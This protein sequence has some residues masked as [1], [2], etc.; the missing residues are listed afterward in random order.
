MGLKLDL[1]RVVLALFILL[2][3]SLWTVEAEVFKTI[4]VSMPTNYGTFFG[5]IHYAEKDL[6]LALKA[7]RIIKEDL[8][9]VV[10]YFEY[11]PHDVVHF[12]LDPYLRLTNGN[13]VVFPT[14]I[15]NLYNFPANNQEHLIVMEN[16]LQGLILHEFVHITHLDQTRGYLAFG[17]KIFGTAAKVPAGVVPRWFT[18]G[19][20]VWG[21]SHLINGGRLNNPL[22]NKDLLIYLK[23]ESYC[24]TIDCLDT[25]GEFPGGQLA[26]WA[27]GHFLEYIENIKPKSIK[28]LVEYNSSSLPFFLNNAFKYCVGEK[29]Q[30]LFK[31]FREQYTASSFSNFGGD[32]I[33]NVFGNDDYQKGVVL[34]GD[35]LFK[36]EVNKKSEALVAYDLLDEVNLIGKFDS[37]ISEI[38]SIVEGPDQSKFLLVSFNDDPNYRNQNKTWKL[39]DPESLTIEKTLNFTHDPSYIVPIGVDKYLTFTYS[40]NHWQAEIEGVVVRTFS[41]LYN[42][43]LVKKSGEQI[44]FKINDGFGTTR[45]ILSD[46]KLQK[47]IEIYKSDK[48]YDLPMIGD[49]FF[50]LRQALELK[51]FEFKK[52]ILVSSLP[53]DVLSYITFANIN[54]D[55]MVVLDS[56]LKTQSASVFDFQ[57]NIN[58][59]KKETKSIEAVEYK[60][61]ESPSSSF[62]SGNAEPYP[63]YDHLL[64]HYWFLASG[65]SDNLG[66]IGATTT[67]SDPMEIYSL[68]GTL[69]TYPSEAKVGGSV[70]YT[71]KMIQIS[72]LFSVS[73]SLNQDYAKT[74]FNSA[75][76]IDRDFQFETKYKHLY[77]KWTYVPGIIAGFSVTEDFLSNQTNKFLGT[78]HALSYEAQSFD[79]FFQSFKGIGTLKIN[80]ANDG[81]SYLSAQIKSE[82]TWRFFRELTG[83]VSGSYSKL[84]KSDFYR[85][86]VYGGGVTSTTKSRD[87]EFYGLP[88]SNAYGNEIF[89]SRFELD[90]NFWDIY[91][92]KNFIP[93]FFKEAHLLGGSDLLYANRIY[94]DGNFLKDKMINSLFIGPRVKMNV[95]YYVPVNMDLIFS[96]IANPNGNSVNQA[97]FTITAAMF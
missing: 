94:L 21:E 91:R 46:F 83:S 69:L 77:K 64:P 61:L 22:F 89:S 85:G 11:A 36:V 62:A 3:L 31:K 73:A 49:S 29:A 4:N 95:F 19:I 59:I 76:I 10:N 57:N 51:L 38:S 52:E 71:Q 58:K 92:G 24:K 17:R 93:F 88:Y 50:I 47:L 26:Y 5:E 16:W 37:P 86:V 14:N 8:I 84:F 82:G 32:K 1:K 74:K 12:N 53:A 55:R 15:I 66:S 87:H 70:D 35:Q 65:T 48:Y 45:L 7:E 30:D 96:K 60:T 9:K 90:Y 68:S 72:D 75:L 67:V 56:S 54:K 44:L 78:S 97:E 28:C 20:A 63:R 41:S 34:E 40:E 6:Q 81:G 25:P 2:N 13:A 27:G 79:D 43:S 23:N 39:I 18:E 33:T 42:I 80:K